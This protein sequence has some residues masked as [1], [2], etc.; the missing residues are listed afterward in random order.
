MVQRYT[1][2]VKSRQELEQ[3]KT[4]NKWRRSVASAAT[5]YFAKLS[6]DQGLTCLAYYNF[7]IVVYNIT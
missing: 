6:Q 1:G 5:F 2:A 7:I 3:G 4:T